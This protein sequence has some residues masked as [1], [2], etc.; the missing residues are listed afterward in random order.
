[1]A[2]PNQQIRV[3]PEQEQVL[4]KNRWDDVDVDDRFRSAEIHGEP[5]PELTLLER[6][7]Q[8]AQTPEIER[9]EKISLSRDD[10]IKSLIEQLATVQLDSAAPEEP[11]HPLSSEP[12]FL[13]TSQLPVQPEETATASGRLHIDEPQAEQDDD[14]NFDELPFEFEIK[15]EAIK[16]L[17]RLDAPV[18]NAWRRRMY[19]AGSGIDSKRL[20]H[21]LPQQGIPTS[22]LNLFS[23][24]FLKGWRVLW[25][26]SPSYSTRKNEYID[27]IR[28][29]S[30][31]T[32]DDY[33]KH[34]EEVVRCYR[35]GRTCIPEMRKR[36]R[37]QGKA[38]R[39]AGSNARQ[40]SLYKE[41]AQHEDECRTSATEAAPAR[42]SC[43]P[44]QMADD[45][46]T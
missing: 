3:E 45:S 13:N 25:E 30:I 28:I 46:R 11:G 2:L 15:K 21:P 44:A 24:S 8:L 18:R 32:H 17:S 41:L 39:D 42:Q 19:D 20:W 10:H 12:A 26:L 38:M 33:E 4:V 37:R 29:W 43:P 14:L 31:S 36:L 27:T 23:T 40:P 22:E 16:Q 5:E 9:S 6:R 35:E 34:I 7:P 1:M